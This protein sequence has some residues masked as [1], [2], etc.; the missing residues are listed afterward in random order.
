MP[1]C[2]PTLHVAVRAIGSPLSSPSLRAAVSRAAIQ[3]FSSNTNTCC[4]FWIATLRSR[5]RK[6]INI[7][8]TVSPAPHVAV[9]AIG[10]PLSS[11]SLRAAASRAAIQSFSSNTNTCC[12]FW[13]ATLRSRGRKRANICRTVSPTPHAR[14]QADKYT[15]D[16]IPTPL[17]RTQDAQKQKSH[18]AENRQSRESA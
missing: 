7:C 3:S 13:I 1:D 14:T 11:P 16:C 4:F 10:S 5:G 2:I 17:A 8:R 15:P 6:R 18:F 9:R 12:F